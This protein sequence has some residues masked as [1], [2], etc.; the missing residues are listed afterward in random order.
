MTNPVIRRAD[1]IRIVTDASTG[2]AES[3][4]LK[5]LRT[6]E[7]TTAVAV[8]WF[9]CNGVGCLARQAKRPSQV[10]QERYDT[11]MAE[12]LDLGGPFPMVCVEVTD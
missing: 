10:F 7:T 5:Y 6:A 9:H 12:H 8:G 1:L 2:L 11:L 3:T 4:I